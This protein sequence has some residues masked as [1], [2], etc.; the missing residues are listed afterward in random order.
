MNKLEE[1]EKALR[2]G[3]QE[4]LQRGAKE[5]S[6]MMDRVALEIAKRSVRHNEAVEGVLERIGAAVRVHNI[7]PIVML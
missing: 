5:Y 2:F 1:Q 4:V 6:V 7:P 3:R